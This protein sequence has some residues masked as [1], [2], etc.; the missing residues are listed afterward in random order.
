M[1]VYLTNEQL[2]NDDL[3]HKVIRQEIEGEYGKF[4]GEIEYWWRS[5]ITEIAGVYVKVGDIEEVNRIET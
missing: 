5:W 1:Y 4:D 3:R 2:C